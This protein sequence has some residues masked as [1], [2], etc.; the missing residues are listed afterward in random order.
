MAL[1]THSSFTYGFQ[2]D[3]TNR[4]MNIDEGGGELLAQLEIGS[5]SLDQMK[6]V[7][8]TALDAI[9]GQTYTVT[10]DRT[11]RRITISA[12]SNFDML[13]NTGSQSGSS[14]WS[15][16]GFGSQDLTSNNLFQGDDPAGS[17]YEPQFFLQSYVPRGTFKEKISETVNESANGTIEVVSFGTREFIEMSIKFITNLEMDGKIILN[18]PSG[19]DDAIDFLT[20]I[21]NKNVFEFMPDKSDPDTFETVILEST[22]GSS[23]GVGYK[24]TELTGKNLPNI[25]EI[26][27][28]KLRVVG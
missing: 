3:S 18:N 15:L 17:F 9:G 14:P 8:K 2:I 24:L 21:T 12:S 28:I 1:G 23:K 13:I 11:T 6:L 5:F 19:L 22:P 16:L 4:N 10:I 20:Y 26:N 25:Y 7:I 27:N